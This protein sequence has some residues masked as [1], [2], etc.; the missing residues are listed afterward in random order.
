MC[1][2]GDAFV[3]FGMG[4]CGVE[5][6]AVCTKDA[7]EGLGSSE[8]VKLGEVGGEGMGGGNRDGGC[9]V[10]GNDRVLPMRASV[11]VAPVE[12]GVGRDGF[13]GG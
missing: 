10:G 1:P 4:G 9:G 8:G 5:K 2:S 11:F 3:Y 13:S 12:S 7:F 6:E